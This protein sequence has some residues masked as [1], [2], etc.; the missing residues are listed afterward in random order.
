MVKVK[1][2]TLKGKP[3][4]K[5]TVELSDV[6]NT[7][8]RADLI[9]RAVLAS[10]ST[11]Y[12]P[13]GVDW[14]AGK[15]T[16]AFSYGTGRDLAR[17]PR[18][19]GSRHQTAGRG[20]I[21]PMAVGGRTA[22]PPIVEKNLVKKI[23]K[24]E[25]RKALA[26]AIA[27]TGNKELVEARGHKTE[28]VPQIP[29][30]VDDALEGLDTAA[31]AREVF[32]K[33]GVWNDIQRAKETTIRAGRGKLRGRK[34][35]KKK[36]VLIVVGED[37]GISLG[38]GNFPGIDIVEAKVLGVEDLAPGTHPGRLT[39]YTKSAVGVIGELAVG[40]SVK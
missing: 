26:S 30:V 33:L 39:I 20:A 22:H 17:L 35:K 5:E 10:Q 24:K 18:V 23:N 21:V 7:G 1:I 16:S 32:M 6:F 8:V 27:A 28:G 40:G 19:K 2:Y 36:S 14:Y 3:K 25:R 38:A 13:Q 4:A 37:K 29:L 15:R 11:R 9:K 31:E 34:Y 12:Q